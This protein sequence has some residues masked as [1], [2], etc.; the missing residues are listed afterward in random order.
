MMYKYVAFHI[1]RYLARAVKLVTIVDPI[2]VRYAKNHSPI[3][4]AD[5][6][7]D[8]DKQWGRLHVTL[9]LFL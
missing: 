2:H 7:M 6:S 8:A 4:F 3:Q 9:T 5:S 1:H